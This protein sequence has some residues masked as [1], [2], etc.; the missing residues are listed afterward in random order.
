MNSQPE[1]REILR[2]VL[3]KDG[4]IKV[5]VTGNHIPSL[6]YIHKLL[7]VEIDKRIINEQIRKATETP[8]GII[9]PGQRGFGHRIM[10]F[11][12]RGKPHAG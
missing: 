12:R 5:T 8:A 4:N 2:A 1:E 6:A 3:T 10:S 9:T 11:V 7:S